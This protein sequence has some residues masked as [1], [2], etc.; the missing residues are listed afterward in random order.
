MV[1]AVERDRQNGLTMAIEMFDEILIRVQWLISAPGRLSIGPLHIAN[2]QFS[3][4]GT[5]PQPRHGAYAER[6]RWRPA[7][8][9]RYQ[10]WS[11]PLR[12]ISSIGRHPHLPGLPTA[13]ASSCTMSEF[14]YRLS[15]GV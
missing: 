14:G 5:L 2:A 12:D 9:H 4:A 1:T 10:Q 3:M 13:R 6:S 7:F 15:V 11:V 8:G